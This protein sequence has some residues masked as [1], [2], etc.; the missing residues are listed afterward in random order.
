VLLPPAGLAPAA[1]EAEPAAAPASARILM[2][3]DEADVRDVLTATLQRAGYSVSTAASAEEAADLAVDDT[4]DLLIT[5]VVLPG[6]SGVEL[7]HR[8]QQ[9]HPGLRTLF[10]SGYTGDAA[11]TDIDRRHFLEKPFST[12]EFL[13]RIDD[14]LRT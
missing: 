3:E 9:A 12:A 1:R 7:A 2:V 13:R 6:I 14:T 10:M 11:L 5:D 4:F 8:L